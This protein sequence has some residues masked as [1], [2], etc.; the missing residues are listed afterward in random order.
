MSAQIVFGDVL[1]HR[2]ALKCDVAPSKTIRNPEVWSPV[3][4]ETWF[5]KMRSPRSSAGR[6]L[7]GDPCD[8][9][10][11]DLQNGH[12]LVLI[13]VV[14]ISRYVQVSRLLLELRGGHVV[15]LQVKVLQVALV[16]Q[17]FDNVLEKFTS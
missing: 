1:L 7:T 14:N 12:L 9:G 16:R 10:L 17:L 8:L 5:K 3:F 2:Y 13:E 15:V 11:I 6:P 4:A